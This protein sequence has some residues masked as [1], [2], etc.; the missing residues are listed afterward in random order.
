[1]TNK[2][3]PTS[4][5]AVWQVLPVAVT[6]VLLIGLLIEN[7]SYSSPSDA[8][9]YHDRVR[10][11]IE[12]VPYQIGDW[13]G[14]DV[15]VPP[16]AIKLLRPNAICS[17]RY[18]N[19]RTGDSVELLIVQTRDA[20]DMGGHYPPVCYPAHGWVQKS[21][22]AVQWEVRSQTIPGQEYTFTQSLPGRLSTIIVDNVLILPNG[23]MI[24]DIEGVRAIAADYRMHF[25]GAGQL[26][27]VFSQSISAEERRAIID[28]FLEAVLPVLEA[29]RS[30]VER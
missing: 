13:F 23:E 7:V 21:V 24:R 4:R 15:E 1:M 19:N 28:V 29:V 6:A 18:Q 20:R 5:K 25:Y 14:S 3:V 11:V 2:N 9:P 12:S 27:L 8:E 10:A 16:A 30:G 26:Q 22:Q 17:R